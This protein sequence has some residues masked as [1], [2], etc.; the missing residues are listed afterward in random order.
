MINEERKREIDEQHEF[1][2]DIHTPIQNEDYLKAQNNVKKWINF[3][4]EKKKDEDFLILIIRDLD[5]LRQ[6]LDKSQEGKRKYD[7]DAETLVTLMNELSLVLICNIMKIEN[8]EKR[9]NLLEWVDRVFEPIFTKIPGKKEGYVSFVH[10]NPDM[11]YYYRVY[12]S[13]IPNFKNNYHQFFKQIEEYE[14]WKKNKN[15]RLAKKWGLI[16]NG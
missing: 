9:D 11:E 7:K 2:V 15:G 1:W 3:F 13:A 8:K 16:K 10:I 14:I 4:V 12:K 5:W 6:D